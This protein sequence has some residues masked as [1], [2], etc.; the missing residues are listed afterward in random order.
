MRWVALIAVGLLLAGCTG[1]ASNGAKATAPTTATTTTGVLHGLV[2]DEAVRP[3]GAVNITA[4][5]GGGV[6][7]ATTGTDGTFRIAGLSPGSYVVSAAKKFY[8]SHE[9][10]VDVHAGVDDP[11]LAKFQL[12]F[13]A[14]SV[15]FAS[16]YKM[17]GFEECGTNILRICSNINI[18]TWIVVCGDTGHRVCLG[19][20]TQDRS[21]LFQSI[22]GIPTF[23]QAEMDW[24]P[25][26]DTGKQMT[27]LIGGGNQTELETGLATAFNVTSGEA[28]LMIRLSNHEGPDTW[29]AKNLNPPCRTPDTLNYSGIGTSRAMLVQVDAGPTYAT[30]GGG[31]GFSAQQPFTL[32]T[33]VFYG[34]EPPADW[35][36]TMT[37][38]PPAPPS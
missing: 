1:G 23:L 8:S 32:F 22:E 30:P 36:F 12:T 5:G 21:V 33:I 15:P 6:W 28:P 29:C 13:E 31:A 25:T 26:L 17:E 9:Q 20:V 37:G 38:E 18:A 16:V 3:L 11:P 4:H 24:T 19:N 10:A 2:V 35:R 34:Y 27:L 14:K 7:N